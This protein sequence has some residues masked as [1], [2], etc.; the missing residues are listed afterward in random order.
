MKSWRY[1][2]FV[3]CAD[4]DADTVKRQLLPALGLPRERVLVSNELPPGQS[5]VEALARGVSDS[6]FTVVILTAAYLRDRWASFGDQ[7][8]GHVWGTEGGLIP[9]LLED[10]AVPLHLDFRVAL[11]LRAPERWDS[12]LERLRVALDQ[13]AR[14]SPDVPKRAGRRER[15]GEARHHRRTQQRKKFP[16]AWVLAAVSALVLACAAV[17]AVLRGGA[18]TR[19]GLA[20][21][22]R[23]D[24]SAD[25][26]SSRVRVVDVGVRD[27]SAWGP[28]ES[29]LEPMTLQLRAAG[30]IVGNLTFELDPSDGH[31][32]VT[33]LTD[34]TGKSVSGYVNATRGGNPSVLMNWDSL[35]F[36]LHERVYLLR[37]GYSDGEVEVSRFEQ[38][39]GP[40]ALQ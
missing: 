29:T 23:A 36:V 16:R 38:V 8:A 34:A 12:E 5:I 2:I 3:V 25:A 27:F 13:P 7:L 14:S 20:S 21:L 33:Q 31:F 37:I 1:D 15:R 9:I 26:V 40:H 30:V 39:T 10:C 4:S 35:R 24:P 11:D 19:S 28:T 18:E 17:I 32:R 22:G 6:R